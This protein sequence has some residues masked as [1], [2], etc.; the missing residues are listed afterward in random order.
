MSLPNAQN[1]IR[2]LIAQR[3]ADRA[4]V[5]T[6]VADESTL[7]GSAESM[8]TSDFNLRAGHLRGSIDIP[9]ILAS[10]Q[11]TM[12]RMLSVFYHNYTNICNDIINLLRDPGPNGVQS[13][14]AKFRRSNANNLRTIQTDLALVKADIQAEYASVIY[15]FRNSILQMEVFRNLRGADAQLAQLTTIITNLNDNLVAAGHDVGNNRNDNVR[16][17]FTASE[18]Q[19]LDNLLVEYVEDY[20]K[21]TEELTYD[22]FF[23]YFQKLREVVLF[24]LEKMLE[25]YDNATN[26]GRTPAETVSLNN[27]QDLEERLCRV[28]SECIVRIFGN[29]RGVHD[30]F[31]PGGAYDP[32]LSFAELRNR[33]SRLS[34]PL[35]VDDAAILG[36]RPRARV[37]EPGLKQFRR[38]LQRVAASPSIEKSMGLDAFK[39]AFDAENADMQSQYRNTLVKYASGAP[40]G[41]LADAAEMTELIT[42]SEKPS[43]GATDINAVIAA[44][45]PPARPP[46]GPPPRRGGRG[47]GGAP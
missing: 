39:R 9:A 24:D 34:P 2:E 1:S 46:R 7:R 37:V 40:P 38:F 18:I 29:N 12:A 23:E 27:M 44:V 6:L 4:L 26:L 47:R 32:A 16:D 36:L 13:K 22:K 14:A 15:E 11:G 3:A 19:D 42:G 10:L 43:I 30:A 31:H 41:N 21:P 5:D 20:D 35:N 33:M 8:L 17:L 28:F 25:F 45:T